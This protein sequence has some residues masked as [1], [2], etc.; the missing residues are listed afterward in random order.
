MKVNLPMTVNTPNQAG[1]EKKEICAKQQK[2]IWERKSKQKRKPVLEHME[3]LNSDQKEY[4]LRKEEKDV[5]YFG[6]DGV[7]KL[8]SLSQQCMEQQG[9]K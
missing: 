3:N 4:T 2:Q 8:F 1:R 7:K 6:V 5:A 9:S